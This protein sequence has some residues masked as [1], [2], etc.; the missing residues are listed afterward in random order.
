MPSNLSRESY[1]IAPYT[2]LL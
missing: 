2:A 1:K